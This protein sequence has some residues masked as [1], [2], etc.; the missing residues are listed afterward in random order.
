MSTK[1]NAKQLQ[2]I[3]CLACGE[4]ARDVAQKLKI[5][6]ETLSRWK[7]IPEFSAEYESVVRSLQDDLRH[8]LI[9]VMHAAFDQLTHVLMLR[10]FGSGD[11]ME[12]ALSL[13]KLAGIDRLLIPP[14]SLPPKP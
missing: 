7:N 8:H 9:S 12:W 6:H 5:R 4:T 13:C 1:L 14:P 3:Y 2:A 10:G 11:R